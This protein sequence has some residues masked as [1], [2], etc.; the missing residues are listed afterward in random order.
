[1]YKILLSDVSYTFYAPTT[2]LDI[3]YEVHIESLLQQQDDAF[4]DHDLMSLDILCCL[5]FDCNV[6]LTSFFSDQQL[7]DVRAHEQAEDFA[8]E[9]KFLKLISTEL[10]RNTT[11]VVEMSV[12]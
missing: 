9:E 4:H 8:R 10:T 3:R 1:M 2:C 7:E 12:L 11:C 5:V 6:R